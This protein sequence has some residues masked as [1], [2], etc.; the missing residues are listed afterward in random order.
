MRS[1]SAAMTWDLVSRG[2]WALSAIA[3]TM[4]FAPAL[5]T[6]AEPARPPVRE[7]PAREIYVPFEELNVLLE[8]PVRRVL[9]TRVASF[10]NRPHVDDAGSLT[11]SGTSA[12]VSKYA[13]TDAAQRLGRSR[14][15]C[16]ARAERC[17]GAFRE[18]AAKS[19]LR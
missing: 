5:A 16:R 8:G 9:M 17:V 4:L 14:F 3:L 15:R 18:L 7:T 2:R 10:H 12:D 6:A 19:D 13:I 1:I 11:T